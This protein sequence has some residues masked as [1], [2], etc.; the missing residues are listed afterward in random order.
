MNLTVRTEWCPAVIFKVELVMK[1]D[2]ARAV[3]SRDAIFDRE[4]I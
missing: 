1:D 4:V 3:L 2:L